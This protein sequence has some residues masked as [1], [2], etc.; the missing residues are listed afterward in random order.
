MPSARPQTVICTYRVRPSQ[1]EAFREQLSRHWPTLR[2]LGMVTDTPP[3]LFQGRDAKER[4]FFV[5]IFEWKNADTPAKAH[6]HPEVM[7]IWE[8]MD[9][10]CES[11]DGQPNME[12]PH[13]ERVEV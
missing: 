3:S 1:D 7:A 4:P 5:E 12:F 2:G 13:V 10:L 6:E 11:R 9:T 8:T